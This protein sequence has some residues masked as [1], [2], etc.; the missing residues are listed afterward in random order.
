MT[1]KGKSILKKGKRSSIVNRKSVKLK[2]NEKEKVKD[3]I[4]AKIKGKNKGI[5]KTKKDIGKKIIKKIK[6]FPPKRKKN[7]S[8]TVKPDSSTLRKLSKKQINNNILLNVQLINPKKSRSKS[9]IFNPLNEVISQK[10]KKTIFLNKRVSIIS[11]SN[12]RKSF[13]NNPPSL[14][15]IKKDKDL[16]F[17][18][19]DYRVLNDQEINTLEYEFAIILDKRTY[20]QYYC[21]L[22]RQKQLILFTF[23]HSNDYNLL[24]LKISLF[25]ISLCLYFTFNGFFFNDKTMHKLYEDNGSYDLI[26]KIPQLLYSTIVSTII[27]MILKTLSLSEKSLLEI[28]GEKD[29]N[30]AIQKSKKIASLL[31]IKF[32]LFFIL[33]ILFMGFFWYF[34][35]CFCAVFINTQIILLKDTALSFTLSMLYPFGLNLFPGFFRIP[36]LRAKNKNKKCLY[37]LSKIIAII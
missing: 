36:S 9:N 13:K 23:F 1:Q 34:I 32:V 15:L 2:T 6:N 35:S 27:N 10:K 16:L 24:T 33:S 19:N 31:N 7:K 20:F 17:N 3:K 4:K 30:I 25:L 21:S 26:Y 37:N 22:L 18:K 29:K 28:K 5:E 11:N 14:S 12:S 8:Y